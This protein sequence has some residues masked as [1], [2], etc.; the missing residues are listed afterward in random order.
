MEPCFDWKQRI[1]DLETSLALNKEVVRT[2]LEAQGQ[3][4]PKERLI[5]VIQRMTEENDKLARGKGNSEGSEALRIQ[6][7]KQ[8]RVQAERYKVFDEIS[9][10]GCFLV[11]QG[12]DFKCDE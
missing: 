5:E 12:E 6:L 7:E 3:S 11:K 10:L 9:Q 8:K 1:T 2:L 4:N